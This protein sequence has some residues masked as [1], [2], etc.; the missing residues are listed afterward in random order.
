MLFFF[1]EKCENKKQGRALSVELC[2]LLF[3]VLLEYIKA[4]LLCTSITT[5][6]RLLEN[7]LWKTCPTHPNFSSMASSDLKCVSCMNTISALLCSFCRTSTTFYIPAD[8]SNII[9]SHLKF[10]EKDNNAVGK[11]K[12]IPALFSRTVFSVA[13]DAR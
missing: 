7:E 5:P 9:F 13:S 10:Y 6:L 3:F 12:R 2:V 11:K 1:K 8:N 4:M